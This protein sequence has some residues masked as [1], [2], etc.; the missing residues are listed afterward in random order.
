MPAAALQVLD[1]VL[2]FVS[3]EMG[4]VQVHDPVAGGLRIVAQRGFDPAALAA[5]PVIG[6]E[7]DSACAAALRT[8]ERVIVHD[9]ASS[10]EFASHRE[11]AASLGYRAQ[12]CTPLRTREGEIVG[13][14]SVH[15]PRPH[16]PS[17][18]ELRTIDL[19]VRPLAHLMERA[20]AEAELTQHSEQ[21]RVLVEGA[22]YGV[23]LFDAEL[24]VLQL[25]PTARQAFG[26]DWDPV[27]RDLHEALSARLPLT[28]PVRI[29]ALVARFRRTL[30]TGEPDSATEWPVPQADGRTEWFDWRVQRIPLANGTFGVV[31]YFVDVS[32]KVES[33]GAIV[34]SEERFRSLVSVLTDVPWTADAAGAFVTPQP[35]WSAFTGRPW[36][37]LRG[38]GWL[39]SLHPEDRAAILGACGTEPPHEM[40][41]RL[42]HAPSQQYR[43]FVARAV[44]LRNSDGS[45]R[46]WVGSC[47]DVTEQRRAEREL[48]E[49]N[50][51]KDEFLA[52]LGH[53]L[54]NPL[55]ALRNAITLAGFD[56]A[57][58]PKALE[59]AGRQVSQLGRLIDDLL[60]VARVTQGQIELRKEP[61]S[62]ADLLERAAEESRPALDERGLRLLLV[63]PREALYVEVDPARIEQ[64]LGNLVANAA[65]YSERGRTVQLVA[66]REGDEAVIRVRDEGIGIAP[67]LLSV[68]FE[69]FAQADRQSSQSAGGLG[70]GLTIVRRLVELHGGRVAAR[71]EGLGKGAEFVVRLPA[72]AAPGSRAVPEAPARA[73]EPPRT[74]VLVVEDN[75]DAAA[76]MRMLLEYLGHSVRVAHDGA[77]ALEAARAEAPELIL[78][79]IGL[80]DMDGYELA[81]RM[82][83]EPAL[84]SAYLV[85]LTGYAG[86]KDRQRARAAG[87]A[88]HLV[89]PVAF[90]TL[91]EL[92]AE[93]VGA[94]ARLTPG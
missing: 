70:I 71:S 67:D 28:E 63:P 34:A 73:A 57:R 20:R 74:R 78:I 80:P 87:F 39:Q 37:E 10:A 23:C 47:T 93:R 56:E 4:T 42:W 61:S 48:R 76:S 1:A 85:A 49:A 65:R 18:R 29:D 5:L 81:R 62:I 41:G 89:K 72:L 64:V 17:A 50:R 60:D 90:E 16:Q 77:T 13:M 43:A 2:A 68:I 86:E 94:G 84:Q 24:R 26:P 55:A 32:S 27:G 14:L 36:E 6:P 21:F 8:D 25:N 83:E 75:R 45:V 31:A 51:R 33:R 9:F 92:F 82:R 3:A 53:E 19:C 91:R 35:A 7:Y 59:I 40:S 58:R 15:F 66:E 12:L 52:M 79:D 46:E 88:R 11:V 30:E 44:P 22:P 38:L 54:R 69:P